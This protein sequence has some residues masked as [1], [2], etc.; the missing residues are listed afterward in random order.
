M[1]TGLFW[2]TII[3]KGGNA[4]REKLDVA[5]VCIETALGIASIVVPAVRAI[6]SK[7]DTGKASVS[8]IKE[9]QK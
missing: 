2:I 3:Q 5:L 1:A 9:K 7:L 4:M 8:Q 6:V